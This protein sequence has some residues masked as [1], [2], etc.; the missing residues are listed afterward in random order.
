MPWENGGVVGQTEQSFANALPKL[1]VVAA[2][3]VGAPNAAAK[4]CVASENPAL[5]FG[6]KADAA[7]CVSWRANH[8]QGALPNFDDLSVFQVE[9]GQIDIGLAFRPESKPNGMA[10]GLRH[11][12]L[13]V[14]MCRHLNIVALLDGGIANDMVDMAVRADNQLRLQLMLVDKAEELVF[15]S[16]RGTARVDD[17]ALLGIVVVNDVSVFR[18]RIEDEGFYFEHNFNL[19]LALRQARGPKAAELVEAPTFIFRVQR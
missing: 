3:K 14:R 15:L 10:F 11:V 2:C 9:V 1:L 5:D 4:E 12:V 13:H 6:V 19:I 16:R 18:K 17:D 8:L 7:S